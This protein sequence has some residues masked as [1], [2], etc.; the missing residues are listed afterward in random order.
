[1]PLVQVLLQLR[2]SHL[3]TAEAARDL[4]KVNDFQRKVV[5]GYHVSS[6]GTLLHDLA[7]F[8]ALNSQCLIFLRPKVEVRVKIVVLQILARHHQEADRALQHHLRIVL[9]DLLFE[10]VSFCWLS[11]LVALFLIPRAEL[12][13]AKGAGWLYTLS[14]E[15]IVILDT[16][17]CLAATNLA[18]KVLD[19]CPE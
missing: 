12:L 8:I 4:I 16:N 11:I 18:D 5:L 13:V 14:L 10:R 1:M 9:F 15:G 17:W 2:L 19:L 3:F 6:Q 7:T